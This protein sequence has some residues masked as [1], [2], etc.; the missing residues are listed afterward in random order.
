MNG[1]GAAA[2]TTRHKAARKNMGGRGTETTPMTRNTDKHDL[3]PSWEKVGTHGKAAATMGPDGRLETNAPQ[4]T[5]ES[6]GNR[7]GDD[8]T[9]TGKPETGRHRR[10]PAET[11]PQKANTGH[12]AKAAPMGKRPGAGLPKRLPMPEKAARGVNGATKSAQKLKFGH[13]RSVQKPARAAAGIALADA[14]HRIYQ[15]EDDNT[16]LEAAHG[17]GAAAETA[18][19]AA[20]RHH[21]TTARGKAAGPAGAGHKLH[22]VPA[23]RKGHARKATCPQSGTP[24]RLL[25]RLRIRREY[26]RA[27]RRANKAAIRTSRAAR[28]GA[29]A[30]AKAGG[31]II[32]SVA[33]NPWLAAVIAL[34]VLLLF[35]L[36]SM[37]GSCGNMASGGMGALLAASYLAEDA[38]IDAAILAYGGRETD[39]RL[40]IQNAGADRPGFDEYRYHI[41]AI[42]HDQHLLVAYLTARYFGFT[43]AAVEADLAAIFAEQ[44]VLTFTET[45][46]TRHADP[47]DED[48]DGD[49]EPY[50]WHVLTVTLASR[51]FGDVIMPRMNAE[52]QTHAAILGAT[53][54]ARQY[55]G[56]PFAID[57]SGHVS[58][59]YGY[60]VHPIDGG[61]D[62]HRGIDIGLPQG[63]PVLAAH[64]GTV[65]FAGA[66]GG[67][68]NIVIIEDGKGIVTKYAHCHTLLVSVGQTVAGG[69]LI[70]TVGSTGNSTGPHLHFEVMKDGQYLNPA[71]H[72]ETGG[73]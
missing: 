49:L 62:L 71:I 66:Q 7:D 1:H 11:A 45:T 12:A 34:A 52:E 55:V 38:D 51:P 47:D 2:K 30:T 58:S 22:P 13:P 57:W 46:E 56:S 23:Q 73:T 59:Q 70:A 65:T 39:L 42:G 68:G 41:G 60:R 61:K 63:T 31:S 10:R 9:T 21:R 16:G 27:V 6:P 36:V 72:A 67:Y 24:S 43:H 32:R 26:A 64:G 17:T 50:D 8:G 28:A 20:Y 40:K 53:M 4:G 37:A 15:T 44:Y 14:R 5:G 35:M 25:Q 54:G 29:Y 48:E 3:F 18:I 69:D 33:G 19:R